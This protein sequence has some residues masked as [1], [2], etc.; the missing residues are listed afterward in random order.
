MRLELRSKYALNT[1]LMFGITTLVMVSIS[2][3][4]ANL[5]S[6]LLAALFWIVM[7]FASTAGLA[8]VFV[9]EEEA[10]TSLILKLTADP[11]AVYVGKL[12][13]NLTLLAAITIVITPFFFM[14][15]NA[16]DANWPTFLLVLVFGVFGL[17][18]GTTLVAAIIA[19]AAIKGA[20][21]AV[22]SFPVMVPLLLALVNV[23]DKVLD[24]RTF[25]DLS[26]LLPFL[27]AYPV[28]MITVSY[29][30]FRFVWQE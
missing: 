7:F 6:N 13:F 18:S 22:L 15:M 26:A 27:I 25:N 9:R 1:I 4:A 14:F 20:L 21:F 16:P 12:L 29:L 17:C 28:I 2:L 5:P 19:K 10:G 23:T 24:G 3:G 30:L 8:Q 11:E